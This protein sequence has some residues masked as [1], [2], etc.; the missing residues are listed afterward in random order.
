MTVGYDEDRA[1]LDAA[2]KRDD[3]FFA[4]FFVS[5]YSPHLVRWAAGRGWSPNAVTILSMGLGTLAAACFAT[6]QRVGLLAGAIVFQLAFVADC[7]DGQL[8]RYTRRFSAL[9]AWLDS[10]F[11]RAKEYVVYAGLAIGAARGSDDVWALAGA[12]LALQTARH[13]VDFGYA[14]AR[15]DD[16]QPLA[17]LEIEDD[18]DPAEQRARPSPR[19][20]GIAYWS[21]RIIVLPIGERFALISLTAAL[22]TP[23]TTFVVLL[24][25]GTIAA[26]Y[27]WT[28][29]VVRSVAR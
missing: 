15:N 13:M 14:A 26:A 28:G 24:A 9:G 11:D 1:R 7:V 23:R 5:P 19:A 3:G 25:W 20:G 22:A 16:P 12:A 6:G 17:R 8:A 27:G 18:G 29:K 2:V 4:T 21:K 10:I